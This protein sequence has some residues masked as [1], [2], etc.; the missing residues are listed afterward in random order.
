M[1][2]ARLAR[3]RTAVILAAGFVV[4]RVVYRVVFGVGAGSGILLVDLPRIQLPVPFASVSLFGPI[5]TGGLLSTA[6]GALPFAAA[7]LAVGLI[8]V[9][10]DLR[11]VVT[12]GTVRGPLRAVARALTIAWSTF[13]ALRD[14]VQRVRIARELRG[15]RSIASLVVPVLEQTVE[16]AIALGASLEVRGF[17]ASR[18]PE[19]EGERPVVVRDASLGFEGRWVLESVAFALAPGTLTLV[20]GPTGSG[21]STLLQA[22]SGLFQHQ[23]A[24]DQSGSIT[25]AGLDRMAEPPRETASFVSVVPQGIRLSF[26]AAT[27]DEE[28]GFA[29]AVRGVAPSIVRERTA[30]VADLL[31]IRY[32][33]GRATVAL[34]AGEACLVA[35]AAALV[36]RP[37]LLLLDEPLTDLD[38]AARA[39]VVDVLDRLAHESGVCVVVAEHAV[40]DW[41]SR[42]DTRLEL[43]AARVLT[44][45]GADRARATTASAG[46]RDASADAV[47][48]TA[49]AQVAHDPVAQVRHLVVVHGGRVAVDDANLSVLAGQVTVLRGANGAGKS[50]LLHALAMPSSTRTRGTRTSRRTV[51]VGGVDVGPLRRRARRRMVAL[52]PEAFDDLLFTTTVAEECRRADRLAG[53]GESTA[54]TFLRFLGVEDGH[55]VEAARRILEQHPR[56]LSAG[57]R[58]CLVMAIQLSARPRL[59]LVDEPTRGLDERARLLVGAAL[60]SAAEAGAAVMVATHDTAFA[61]RNA[62]RTLTMSA[63]QRRRPGRGEQMTRLWARPSWSSWV[64]GA[65]SL[66]AFAGF[67]WPLLAAAAPDEAQASV[68]FV[69]VAL[70]PALLIAVALT[71]DREMYTAQTVALLGVLTA[72]GAAV[73]IAEHRGRGDRGR[74]HPADPGGPRLR[75]AVR[76]PARHHDDRAVLPVL[77]RNRSVDAVP[78]LRVRVGRGGGRASAPHPARVG[79]GV[80]AARDRHAGRLRHP[81]VVCIRP[82][83]E[84]LVLAV[85][86]RLGHGHLVPARRPA[87]SEPGLVRPVLLRD[88]DRH[89]GYGARRD[90]GGGHPSRGSGR[91]CRPAPREGRPGSGD[92]ASGDH[93]EKYRA[94][95]WWKTNASVDCS[96]CSCSSSDSSTPIRSGLS[97]STTLRRSS[98]FGQAG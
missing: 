10:V 85:R 30:E 46:H 31:A 25:V 29:L 28:L 14:S 52:V 27:V 12:M 67:A 73:R 71:L 37:L 49:H 41:A 11:A 17:A 35:I 94:S 53:P 36:S 34:S 13:P 33:M 80:V 6:L 65:A 76:T 7:I 78:G 38:T 45:D 77:G 84:S 97:S 70:V 98:M 5:T 50:S 95:G 21:K 23:L 82:D 59:L 51:L 93:T 96:G 72:V 55:D 20:T 69:A 61:E 4:L 1:L 89:L 24:G 43:A 8:G 58:L 18:H 40:Q 42:V 92:P 39:R 9:V 74:L 57:E 56:D 64:L 44:A 3:L 16:R 90:V 81:G 2:G 54:A 32:L 83:H 68:P 88:V 47:R 63:G 66:V 75:R 79:A 48:A 91:A 19:P 22:M 26:V 86:R 62:D 60:R 15:E 87:G